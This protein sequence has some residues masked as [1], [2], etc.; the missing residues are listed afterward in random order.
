MESRPGALQS[1][2]ASPLGGQAA[3][4]DDQLDADDLEEKMSGDLAHLNKRVQF[5][6]ANQQDPGQAGKPGLKPKQDELLDDVKGPLRWNFSKETMKQF[7]LTYEDVKAKNPSMSPQ[8][9][10]N[11]VGMNKQTVQNYQYIREINFYQNLL[12]SAHNR[13]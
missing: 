11:H 5:R 3:D 7:G 9:I 1:L 6:N 8:R 13:E 4:L 10:V 12:K 2:N